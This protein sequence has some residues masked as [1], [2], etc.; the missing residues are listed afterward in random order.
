M[1]TQ[2]AL[3]LD[4]KYG[5]F[6]LGE[7]QI[8]TPG[9]GDLLVRIQAVGLNPVDWFISKYGEFVHEYPAILGTD[10]A[11]TVEEVGEG[12]VG[13]KKGDR[14]YGILCLSFYAL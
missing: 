14:M 13:F 8:P 7:N 5:K 10:I 4:S 12:A 11:G 1:V 9:R 3:Y 6:V 2:K